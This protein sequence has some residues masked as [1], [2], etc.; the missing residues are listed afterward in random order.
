[1]FLVPLTMRSSLNL[2]SRFSPKKSRTIVLDDV[3]YLL[4]WNEEYL[5]LVSIPLLGQGEEQCFV[6]AIFALDA[7]IIVVDNTIHIYAIAR[8][9]LYCFRDRLNVFT[10]I[11]HCFES[12]EISAWD[13][14]LVVFDR[15]MFYS[16]TGDGFR[17]LHISPY[18][19]S[20]S[21]YTC[22]KLSDV[23]V[24][25]YQTSKY[26]SIYA[27]DGKPVLEK[28]P[29]VGSIFVR[30][31]KLFVHENGRFIH[32]VSNRMEIL[33]RINTN[34]K[35][36]VVW[37]EML[38]CSEMLC[39]SGIAPGPGSNVLYVD[40][41]L[42]DTKDFVQSF[43]VYRGC[44]IG[45]SDSFVYFLPSDKD[46]T[47]KLLSSE[48]RLLN[49]ALNGN[50]TPYT[51]RNFGFNSI[52]SIERQRTPVGHFLAFLVY[53]GFKVE[54]Y[55]LI[56]NNLNKL[57]GIEGSSSRNHDGDDAQKIL[58]MLKILNEMGKFGYKAY[59]VFVGTLIDA[60]RIYTKATEV[61]DTED[62]NE[63]MLIR[64]LEISFRNVDFLESPRYFLI[65]GKKQM[66]Q[67][68]DFMNCF[69]RC[70]GMFDEVLDIL[71]QRRRVVEIVLIW[72]RT[73]NCRKESLELL[74][75]YK[76]AYLVSCEYSDEMISGAD[77][78]ECLCEMWSR[79][80]RKVENARS[81][82]SFIDGRYDLVHGCLL[83]HGLRILV[84]PV[85][86][87]IFLKQHL[88]FEQAV[89]FLLH[90]GMKTEAS[91][92]YYC[93]FCKTGEAVFADAFLKN[94]D[95]KVFTYEGKFVGKETFDEGCVHKRESYRNNIL[96]NLEIAKKMDDACLWT[97]CLKAE[98]EYP[99][100]YEEYMKLLKQKGI[101]QSNG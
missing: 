88:H 81:I 56:C 35:R 33:T 48:E 82:V 6:K 4:L 5:E 84:G 16:F 65:K 14:N 63:D 96:E 30:N 7:S 86:V 38:Y 101:K 3:L 1:M 39:I 76:L 27:I 67:G 17:N 61:I 9:S 64:M 68:V 69:Y 74:L 26:T 29:F 45:I 54:C 13:R 58:R 79:S 66:E 93:K 51:C 73:R 100:E 99:N 34:I 94:I 12:P 37:K 40:G 72:K 20:V 59:K 77:V 80:N 42:F 50:F 75:K 11:P 8:N 85:I 57:Q 46:W 28:H 43:L 36:N 22:G 10:E 83:P 98:D 89:L 32:E 95:E 97:D 19:K 15:N 2:M 49:N 23:D 70:D 24:I 62:I 18:F 71:E 53:C 44:F 25:V 91:M 90:N 31:G 21:Y 60:E 47:M 92:L 52:T 87:E 41:H 78:L 55:K